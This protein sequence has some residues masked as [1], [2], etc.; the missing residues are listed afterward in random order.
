MLEIVN[1]ILSFVLITVI[2]VGVGLFAIKCI[3]T[4]EQANK[5]ENMTTSDKAIT[6]IMDRD[7]YNEMEESY[8][9]VSGIMEKFGW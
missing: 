4:V 9:L 5:F 2:G 3:D 7:S 8:D 6:W 1:K